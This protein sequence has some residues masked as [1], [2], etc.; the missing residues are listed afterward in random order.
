[1]YR[2]GFR[3]P[4]SR[5][6]PR[7]CGAPVSARARCSS[8]NKKIYAKIEAWRNRRIEGEHPHLYLD[9]IVMKRSWGRRGPQ[10]FA[11][12]G[13]GCQF[14]KVSRDPGGLGGRQGRQIR[15]VGI[16]PPPAT[17]RPCSW[18][19]PTPAG[20]LSRASRISC[21]RRRATNA[22]WWYI[23]PATSSATS[24]RPGFARSA[25]CSR[26]FMPRRAVR[27]PTRSKGNRRLPA[28]K[29]DG[30]GNRSLEQAV[31]ICEIGPRLV[32]LLC[33]NRRQSV[34][35]LY[36]AGCQ[37]SAAQILPIPQLSGV[38]RNQPHRD[39]Q[40]IF[41]RERRHTPFCP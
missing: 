17:S 21:R 30:Q 25:I 11:A 13:L 8:L 18:S 40:Q 19:F 1:M 14:S 29:Q 24:L 9:G 10:R 37:L 20:A 36:G 7:R 28:T 23:F 16:P 31:S 32:S 38:G 27:Q 22:A 3:S 15:L 26:P 35:Q 12:G 39:R 34:L 5:T 6:S 33:A 41:G 2:P 4:G